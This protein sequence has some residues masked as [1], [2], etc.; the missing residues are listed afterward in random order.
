MTNTQITHTELKTDTGIFCRK[1]TTPSSKQPLILV[2]GYGG[3][4]RVWPTTL[5][6]KLAQTFEVITYDNRGTGL[7]LIPDALEDYTIKYMSEDIVSVLAA[8]NLEGAHMLGYS[9][10]SCIALQHAFD[11]PNHIRSLVLLCGTAGGAL[12][13][14]PDSEISAVL[15]NP[16]GP[17]LWDMYMSTWKVMFSAKAFEDCMPQLTAMFENS[18]LLSTK[19]AALLGHSFAFRGF[20]GSPYLAKI[21]LPVTVIAGE[22]DRLMPVQNS[23]NIA[24]S[25]PNARLVLIPECEHCPHVEQ[26]DLVISEIEKLALQSVEVA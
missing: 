7:S 3:S 17:T 24:E 11:H 22:T 12:Y 18:K 13:A 23:L 5:I 6:E 25:M 16:Q 2:M 21:T 8:F 14:K 19:P 20:D 1:T 9:M 15:A 10:G 4:L 26:E